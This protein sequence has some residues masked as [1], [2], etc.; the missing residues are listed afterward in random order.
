MKMFCNQSIDIII[1]VDLRVNR[2]NYYHLKIKIET[3]YLTI[4]LT[5]I[6]ISHCSM[7]NKNSYFDN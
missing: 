3:S 4:I 1:Y 5:K 2:D 6:Q 7:T